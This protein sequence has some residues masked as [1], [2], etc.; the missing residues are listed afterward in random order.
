MNQ[1]TLTKKKTEPIVKV[2][3]TLTPEQ[4]AVLTAPEFRIDPR[5]GRPAFLG[6]V[7]VTARPAYWADGIYDIVIECD[8]E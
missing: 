3:F 6:D 7:T 4:T 1:M 8:S 2:T 5:I